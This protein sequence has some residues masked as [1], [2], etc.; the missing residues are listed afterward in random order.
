MPI[1]NAMNFKDISIRN[2]V[3][4]FA[5]AVGALFILLG[6]TATVQVRALSGLAGEAAADTASLLAFMT[7]A[8][9]A[10]IV[11]GSALVL[12]HISRRIEL[13]ADETENLRAGDCDLTR[14]LPTMSGGLGKLCA[15]L[16][17]FVAQLHDLV[18]SVTINAG[19]IAMAARQISAGNTDLS[20]RTE[21]QASTLEETASSMEQFTGSVR[22]TADN[23]KRASAQS[24]C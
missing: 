24:W 11:A 16:N 8:G 2:A 10:G 4:L 1:A 23:T 22:Q 12:R 15:S 3:R 14:R 6:V 9:L 21:Q 5:A 17:G 13:V 20:A 18:S 7:L 19:E